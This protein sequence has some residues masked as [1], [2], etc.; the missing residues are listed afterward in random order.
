MGRC[1]QL[2]ALVLC[3]LVSNGATAAEPLIRFNLTGRTLEGTPLTWSEKRVYF[4][5]RD[6]QMSEFAPAEATNYSKLPGSFQS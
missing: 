5:G 3:G 6:G 2:G 1:V 4:L